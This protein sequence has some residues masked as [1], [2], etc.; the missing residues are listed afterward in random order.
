MLHEMDNSY[1]VGSV[2]KRWLRFKS[3]C[4]CVD[5]SQH[6]KNAKTKQSENVDPIL[7]T[8]RMLKKIIFKKIFGNR[9]FWKPYK[10]RFDKK[11]GRPWL[12]ESEL[13]VILCP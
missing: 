10:N 9:R 12:S 8:L 11:V 2:K 13:R 6:Q 4:V 5:Q 7:Q 1:P 3:F